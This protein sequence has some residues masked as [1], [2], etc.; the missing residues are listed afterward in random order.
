MY[1]LP[2]TI[3][4]D[5]NSL[6]EGRY[7]DSILENSTQTAIADDAGRGPGSGRIRPSNQLGCHCRGRKFNRFGAPY[8]CRVQHR[9][10][11]SL[12]Q[13]VTGFAKAPQ[14]ELLTI[15][16][17]TLLERRAKCLFCVYSFLTTIWKWL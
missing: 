8:H 16:A 5:A 11:E 13:D 1:S 4:A 7:E 12:A 10:H 3:I 9:R 17:G 2:Q 15:N 6:Q 14:G